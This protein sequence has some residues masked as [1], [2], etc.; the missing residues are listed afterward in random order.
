MNW[1][2]GDLLS[3]EYLLKLG[4]AIGGC[5]RR[6]LMLLVSDSIS[7]R[8]VWA[9]GACAYVVHLAVVVSAL[10]LTAFASLVVHPLFV[11]WWAMPAIASINKLN[12]HSHSITFDLIHKNREIFLPYSIIV[13]GFPSIR[14]IRLMI[15]FKEADPQELARLRAE[16]RKNRRLSELKTFHIH[17]TPQQYR[18]MHFLGN[19]KSKEQSNSLADPRLSH[20]SP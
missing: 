4:I 1:M 16:R 11:P 18:G 20:L 14:F 8:S 9:L 6:P 5:L 13:Y 19:F 15:E 17:I 12:H 7:V 3:E 10:L 2:T